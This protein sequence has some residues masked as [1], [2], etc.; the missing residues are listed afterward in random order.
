MDA[1]VLAEPNSYG[2]FIV[3]PHSTPTQECA[4]LKAIE[5][6]AFRYLAGVLIN[7]V[8]ILL[9][10]RGLLVLAVLGGTALAEGISPMVDITGWIVVIGVGIW[11]Y[12]DITKT[13]RATIEKFRNGIWS[14]FKGLA[15]Q[16]LDAAYFDCLNQKPECCELFQREVGT[17][18]LQW[19]KSLK[20]GWKKGNPISG[21]VTWRQMRRDIKRKIDAPLR[22]CCN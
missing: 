12:L 6:A 14:Q 10:K 9:A 21:S 15:H 7:R 16:L 19:V 22:K 4:L 1:A 18:L 17:L 13:I 2:E 5:P 8:G 20:P 11:S 3:T